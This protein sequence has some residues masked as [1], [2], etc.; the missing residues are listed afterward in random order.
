[1]ALYCEFYLLYLKNVFK[2]SDNDAALHQYLSYF[3]V[4]W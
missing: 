1:M 4:S 3:V 2:K